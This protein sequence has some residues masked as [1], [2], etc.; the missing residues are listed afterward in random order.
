[1][2]LGDAECPKC[3]SKAK[4][5]GM[6][7]TTTMYIPETYDEEGKRVENVSNQSSTELTCLNKECGHSYRY[8]PGKDDRPRP[9]ANVI[10]DAYEKNVK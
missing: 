9:S 3:G 6:T 7:T 2:F 10:S 4:S 1:M 8:T 5:V